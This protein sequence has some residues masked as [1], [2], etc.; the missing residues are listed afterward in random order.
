MK[1]FYFL[2]NFTLNYALRIFYPRAGSNN[3]PKKFLGSTIFV[4]NHPASFMDP[5]VVAAF[6]RPIVY[7]M[8]RSDV[9]T[10]LST[11][12]LT[13]V[14]ML[15]IYRQLDGLDTKKKN[16]EVFQRCSK[17]LK[18]GRNLLI[19]GEG[20]TDDVFIRRLK[21]VKKGAVRIGFIALE[22]NG[23]KDPI[24]IAACGINYTYPNKMRSGVFI[25]YSDRICLNDFKEEYQENPNKVITDISREIE[26]LLQAQI[27]HVEELS[28]TDTHERIMEVTAKGMSQF[29]FDKSIPLKQRWKY[30]KNLANWINSKSI[31]DPAISKIK[32]SLEAYFGLLK[33]M[34]LNES[35]VQWKLNDG[36]RFM[37]LLLLIVLFP[38][39]LIGAF[40][41]FLPYHF[42]K[43]FV[44]KSFK[45][46]VF[47]G[48]VKVIL[49][50]FSIGIINIPFI[51]LFY[52]LI[53]PSW[54]MSICYYLLIGLF[55]LGAYMWFIYLNRFIRK[56]KLQQAD[57]SSIIKRRENIVEILKAELP[58]ELI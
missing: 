34:K 11:P 12:F 4:S 32:S 14:H 51:F 10:K 22:E 21:P 23:W 28:L 13:S 15:P 56:G 57:M 55:G 54:T 46:K 50:K 53:Y 41:C 27:T 38:V 5:L 17:I 49:G 7:F 8:T 37:E 52:Y 29:S 26:L 9:F 16:E 42:I 36:K 24:Y 33:K 48:S 35:D 1:F 2:L 30:S 20:F 19:F 31:E 25:S 6:Q 47:W 44:E 18:R 58:S 40:H 43:K 45:R 3:A 39:M